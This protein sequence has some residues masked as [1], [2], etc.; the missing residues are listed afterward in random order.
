MNRNERKGHVLEGAGAPI[1]HDAAGTLIACSLTTAELRNRRSLL[2]AQF[3]SVAIQA[4]ELEHGYVFRVPG[5]GKWI[6]LLAQLIVAERECCPF[7]SFEMDASPNMGPV[8]LG[9]AGPDGT[10]KFLRSILLPIESTRAG[11]GE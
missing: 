8:T 9:V 1:M 10:K 6:E 2:L 4:E 3:R 7:L 5:D 11:A